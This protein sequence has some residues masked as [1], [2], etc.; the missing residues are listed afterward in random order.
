MLLDKFLPPRQSAISD[1]SMGPGLERVAWIKIPL[2][3]NKWNSR[4]H[5]HC[6]FTLANVVL[7]LQKT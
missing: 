5:S 2:K 1:T 7:A 3:F 6:S 4:K